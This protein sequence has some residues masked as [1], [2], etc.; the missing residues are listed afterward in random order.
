MLSNERVMTI[1]NLLTLSR[2]L[3]TPFIVLA[4]VRSSWTCAFFLLVVAGVTDMLDGYL[5]RWLGQETKLGVLLDPIADKILLL[6]CFSA[7]AWSQPPGLVVPIWFVW[8]LLVREACIVLG[9]VFVLWYADHRHQPQP[10]IGPTK[11][12][13][14]TTLVQLLLI[15]WLLVCYFFSWVPAKT[16]WLT[17]SCVVLVTLASF[18]HYASIGLHYVLPTRK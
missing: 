18:V 4:I 2:I 10:P 3:F 13:K 5:A 12:G 11:W 1:S 16:Y 7:L 6:S 14:L 9:S 15:G 17:F 8:L